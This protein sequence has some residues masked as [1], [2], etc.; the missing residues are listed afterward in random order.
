[1]NQVDFPKSFLDILFILTIFLR[2]KVRCSQFVAQTNLDIEQGVFYIPG[3]KG[4][5]VLVKLLWPIN[6][7]QMN[8]WVFLVIASYN[9]LV[10][11]WTCLWSHF[12]GLSL[13]YLFLYLLLSI[14]SCFS[15]FKSGINFPN[16]IPI[17]NLE[18]ST[19]LQMGSQMEG[20]KGLLKSF[21][22][23]SNCNIM[24][25]QHIKKFPL[26]EYPNQVKFH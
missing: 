23:V 10:S 12:H 8:G 2:Y 16:A 6:A 15:F 14:L 17:F 26:A 3:Q 7:T 22:K 1:M 5:N 20:D 21:L 24:T 19:P 18:A 4:T 13:F 11:N 25:L 9:N